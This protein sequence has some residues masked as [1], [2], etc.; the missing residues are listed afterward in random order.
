ME[1]SR[2]AHAYRRLILSRDWLAAKSKTLAAFDRSRRAALGAGS[3]E[4]REPVSD[5]NTALVDRL[6]ALDRLEKRTSPSHANVRDA[7]VS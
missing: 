1:G 6:K 2:S 3:E 4:K 5:I 7:A